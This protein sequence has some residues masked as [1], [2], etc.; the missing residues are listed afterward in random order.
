MTSGSSGLAHRKDR[1]LALVQHRPDGVVHARVDDGEP[2]PVV[3]LPVEH[4]REEDA[5]VPGDRAAGL[6]EDPEPAVGEPPDNRA[7][8]RFGRRW[9]LPLVRDAETAPEVERAHGDPAPAE[10]RHELLQT[11]ERLEERMRAR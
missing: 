4:A 10:L 8:V 2:F 5:G 11:I 6:D 1:V 3:L 9:R 7:P